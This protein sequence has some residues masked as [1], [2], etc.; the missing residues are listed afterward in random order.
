M[1]IFLHFHKAAG[2]TIVQ[3][4]KRKKRFFK[5]NKNG[6]PAYQISYNKSATIDYWSP[7]KNE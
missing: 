4:L 3:I 1:I 6:N 5:P 7:N 2:S